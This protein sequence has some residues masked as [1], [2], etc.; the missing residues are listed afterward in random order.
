M[1]VLGVGF[2]W[3]EVYPNFNFN[4]HN[5]WEEP[6]DLAEF[7]KAC[8]FIKRSGLNTLRM[9]IAL[10]RAWKGRAGNIYV[11][12]DYWGKHSPHQCH[13]EEIWVKNRV[14]S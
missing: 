5:L 2:M 9:W 14:V 10:D 11:N 6:L 7:E 4:S 13:C 3:G 1:V 12:F 8:D